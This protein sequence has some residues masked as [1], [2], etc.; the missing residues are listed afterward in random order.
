MVRGGGASRTKLCLGGEVDRTAKCQCGGLQAKV[1]G[2][3]L[4]VLV[5][6]CSACQHRTGAPFSYAAYFL[7]SEV[8]IEGLKSCYER[9]GQANRKLRYI[10][11]PRAGLQ[12]TGSLILD[13]TVMELRQHCSTKGHF[14]HQLSQFGMRESATGCCSPTG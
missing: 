12:Y 3:P 13:Q 10:F 7:R 5:C 1:S 14:R 11:V 8:K 6:H 2:D 9:D 4:L